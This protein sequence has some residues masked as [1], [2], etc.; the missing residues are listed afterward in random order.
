MDNEDADMKGANS[1]IRET[2]FKEGIKKQ[3]FLFGTTVFLIPI[4][5]KLT[6]L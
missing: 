6:E 5:Q 1:T 2:H 3:P 4:K